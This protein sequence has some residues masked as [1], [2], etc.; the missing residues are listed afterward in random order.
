MNRSIIHMQPSGCTKFAARL[1][2]S[3]LTVFA[4]ILDFQGHQEEGQ[5]H[6]EISSP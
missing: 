4:A 2:A 6:E 1:A 3:G 5:D